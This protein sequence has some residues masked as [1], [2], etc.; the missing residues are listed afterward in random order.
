MPSN[1]NVGRSSFGRALNFVAMLLGCSCLQFASSPASA[2]ETQ[3]ES[4][5]DQVARLLPETTVGLVHVPSATA[6]VDTILNHPLRERIEA[7]PEIQQGKQSKQYTAFMGGVALF[8]ASMTMAWPDTVSALS[9]DGLFLAVDAPS[10]GVV[11]LAK[12]SS[13]EI[14]QRFI[15]TVISTVKIANSKAKVKEADYDRFHAY[16]I[17]DVLITQLDGWLL[18]TNKPE[19]AKTIVDRYI[20]LV[21]KNS[22]IRSDS[23]AEQEGFQSAAKNSSE[24]AAWAY[25]NIAMIRDSGAAQELYSGKSENILAEAI[26]GGILSNLR[27]T[28]HATAWLSLDAGDL[29]LSVTLPHQQEWIG[30]REYFFGPDNSGAAPPH[31][32]AQDQIGSLTA[33]RNLAEMWL[34]AGDLLTEKAADEL[35]TADS[36]LSTFFSG[37]DFGEDILGGLAPDIQIVVSEQQFDGSTPTPVVKLPAFALQFRM[38]DPEK[39]QSDMRRVFLSLVGF[40]NVVGAM[41]GQPQLDFA[42]D[43]YAGGEIISTKY[44]AP[45]KENALP[46][47]TY[48]AAAINYNFTP[49]IGFASDRIIVSSSESLARELIAPN[50]SPSKQPSSQQKASQHA[51]T[52]PNTGIKLWVPPIASALRANREQLIAQNMLEK[53][54]DRQAAESEINL[55]LTLLTFVSDA[56][57]ELRADEDLTVDAKIHF[58]KE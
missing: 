56:E 55:L 51:A 39:M 29:G 44:I 53:G 34:R 48:D 37:R 10:K 30:E 3:L 22:E 14:T 23:L 49:S 40:L 42:M 38:L 7:L 5:F 27:E 52:S 11:A 28:P 4:V 41:E 9:S 58:S 1:Q 31:I 12:G 8:E 17:D 16:S 20:A 57:I 24:S 36:T 19:L 6:I 25:L 45:D 47:N 21:D 54:H 33:Y 2:K 43:S 15:K 50:A 32:V 35:A 26:F 13:P 46:G 18:A